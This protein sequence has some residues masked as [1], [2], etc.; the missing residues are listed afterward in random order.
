MRRFVRHPT[1]IPID[2][3]SRALPESTGDVSALKNLSQ[4][5]MACK[6]PGEVPVGTVVNI[7]IPS[8]SPPYSGQGVIVWCQ[9]DGQQFEVGVRFIDK[10][11]AFKARMVQQVC[12]I[13]AYKRKV[14]EQEGRVLDSEQA[15]KEWIEKYAAEFA[16][17]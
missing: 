17:L 14:F 2:V 11:E 3:N 12:Q 16:P 8:V 5:G 15:A 7:D 4:D 9:Q 10:D 13:E 6:V 1:N